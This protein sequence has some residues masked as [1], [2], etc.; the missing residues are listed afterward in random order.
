MIKKSQSVLRKKYFKKLGV[1]VQVEF[2]WGA[3]EVKPPKLADAI[4]NGDRRSYAA[5]RGRLQ[6]LASTPERASLP[7]ACKG[8]LH[9]LR[10]ECEP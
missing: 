4:A 6:Y 1:K 9:E 10:R 3:T 8:L 7:D 5:E 2:S